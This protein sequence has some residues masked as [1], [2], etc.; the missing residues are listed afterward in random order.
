MS[1]EFSPP[2]K[3]PE[4]SYLFELREKS[5]IQSRIEKLL[6][7]ALDVRSSEA[8][9][10]GIVR[11]LIEFGPLNSEATLTGVTRILWSAF[12]QRYLTVVE[13]S[14]LTM[15]Q[16]CLNLLALS[17]QQTA[18]ALELLSELLKAA[19]EATAEA[20]QPDPPQSFG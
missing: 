13:L 3:H 5:A 7:S 6:A 16:A 18:E 12:L 15:P 8:P 9:Q 20:V 17:P 1:S 19:R 14:E 2:S 11:G 4:R 10:A